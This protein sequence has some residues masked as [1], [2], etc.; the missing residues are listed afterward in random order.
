M[1]H[2]MRVGALMFWSVK[3]KPELLRKNPSANPPE[4]QTLLFVIVSETALPSL[5]TAERWV[6]SPS[7]SDD[8]SPT[9][10][11]SCCP[12]PGTPGIGAAAPYGSYLPHSPSGGEL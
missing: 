6:V 3:R 2:G 4:P 10:S 12:D 5:S 1:R 11:N 8:R 7:V 9:S